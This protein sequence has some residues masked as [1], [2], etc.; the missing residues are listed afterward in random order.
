MKK[1]G[2]F[3]F[4]LGFVGIIGA[5]AIAPQEADAGKACKRT[6][7]ETKLVGDACQ[8]GGQ[9]A[10]KKAMKGWLKKAKKK[11]AA[12][13]CSSCHTKLA[14]DYPLKADGLEHFKRLGGK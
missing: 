13:E 4:V 2:L 11:E 10:A 9:A 7:F 12:L 6:T 14:P 3:A 5:V 1:L 8:A